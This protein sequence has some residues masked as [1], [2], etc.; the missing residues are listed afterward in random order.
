MSFPGAGFISGLNNGNANNPGAG[1]ISSGNQQTSTTGNWDGTNATSLSNTNNTN[2]NASGGNNYTIFGNSTGGIG[3]IGDNTN[4][5]TNTTTTITNTTNYQNPNTGSN[6][7]SQNTFNAQDYSGVYNDLTN[8]TQKAGEIIRGEHAATLDKINK[9]LEEY[10][11]VIPPDKDPYARV[12]ELSI[13][14]VLRRSIRTMIDVINDIS[15]TISDRSVLSVA[16]FRRQIVY[17]ITRSDRR[18]YMG[19]WLVFFSFVFYFIDS[20]S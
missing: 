9:F 14:E 8:N 2:N 3:N 16:D 12:T 6:A 10:P 4:N 13:K 19:V 15:K 7:T 5:G 18:F 11:K 17:A 20:A 1:F